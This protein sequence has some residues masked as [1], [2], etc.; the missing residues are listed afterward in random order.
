[1]Y[2]VVDIHRKYFLF[3]IFVLKT[4]GP[5]GGQLGVLLNQIIMLWNLFSPNLRHLFQ[6]WGKLV[7]SRVMA[8][9]ESMR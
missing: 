7:P 2:Y 3:D 9:Y 4:A 5:Q 1:M 6:I 8:P